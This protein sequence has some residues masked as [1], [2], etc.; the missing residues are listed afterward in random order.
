MCPSRA[1]A[2]LSMAS[3]HTVEGCYGRHMD[4]NTGLLC[5]MTSLVSALMI[6]A[7]PLAVS[8]QD[9][10]RD[11]VDTPSANAVVRIGGCTGAL[12]T[13]RI[14]L[15]A[16]HCVAGIV[17]KA[18][19]ETSLPCSSLAQQ[20]DLQRK[21]AWQNPMEFH[22]IRTEHKPIIRFGSNEDRF[23][24]GIRATHYVLPFCAD[25]ALLRLEQPVPIGVATPLP[26]LV[27]LGETQG[28]F[29]WK[30]LPLRHSGWGEAKNAFHE[31]P[32]RRTGPV[33]PWTE[34]ACMLFTLPPVRKDGRR[35]VNG[36]SGSPLIAQGPQ[37]REFVLGVIFGRGVPDAESCGL[38]R[39][40]IP[41]RHGSYTPTW[42]GALDDT[43]ATPLGSWIAHHAP[44]AAL[45]W[46]DLSPQ[47]R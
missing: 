14:V 1:S 9:R 18:P 34:N 42:R 24:L 8:A 30:S 31:K 20:R 16:A 7:S 41:K 47:T 10:T 6:S 17:T 40:R 5:A 39:L 45:L 19:E 4:R 3:R 2:L 33:Q 12:I 13:E 11:D 27:G 25:M 26:V 22:L 38:P 35:I 44:E 46:T 21:P 15:T 36:D 28:P 32:T 29:D 43:D 37:G 23:G